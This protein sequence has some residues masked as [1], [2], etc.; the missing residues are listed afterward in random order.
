LA[1]D[2]LYKTVGPYFNA[3]D[4]CHQVPQTLHQLLQ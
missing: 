4:L 2:E 3:S 1:G